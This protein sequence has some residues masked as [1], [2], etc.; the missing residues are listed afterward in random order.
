[1]QTVELGYI[2]D[3]TKVIVLSK[4]CTDFNKFILLRETELESRAAYVESEEQSITERVCITCQAHRYLHYSCCLQPYPVKLCCT[5]PSVTAT[6][7]GPMWHEMKK[8]DKRSAILSSSPSEQKATK[9][10]NAGD[11]NESSNVNEVILRHATDRRKVGIDVIQKIEKLQ[12]II[13]S[14]VIEITSLRQVDTESL[15]RERTTQV[16]S[17]NSSLTL[18]LT[19]LFSLN[20][21]QIVLAHR[22]WSISHPLVYHFVIVSRTPIHGKGKLL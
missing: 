14:Q 10:N 5:K 19:I 4:M 12:N 11:D 1:M 16:G 15:L 2:F 13:R 22:A 21:Q 6:T 17:L 7:G 9:M 3:A 20:H 8:D 18:L